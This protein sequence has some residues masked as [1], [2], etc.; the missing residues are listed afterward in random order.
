MTSVAQQL[1]YFAITISSCHY[2]HRQWVA[3][4][5]KAGCCAKHVVVKPQPVCLYA[6]L[7]TFNV[8]ADIDSQ[9]GS[10]KTLWD[11]LQKKLSSLEDLRNKQV[12]LNGIS[13]F[14]V[15]WR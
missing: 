1:R 10:A 13:L 8:H 7:F 2:K 15:D 6:K 14:L 4:R 12:R 9:G 5:M 3:Q 11:E